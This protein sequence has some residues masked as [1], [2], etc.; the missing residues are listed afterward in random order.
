MSRSE[1]IITADEDRVL[2]SRSQSAQ[3]SPSEL[4][5]EKPLSQKGIDARLPL[6]RIIHDVF[7]VFPTPKNLNIWY[8]FGSI[9]AFCVGVQI[10]T[11]VVLAMHYTANAQSAFDAIEH[12]IRGV[13]Y[14]WLLPHG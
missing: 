4:V 8:T 2:S 6:P 14:S 9:L 11:G 13:N 7:E 1:T 10:L 3:V 12:I 5:D